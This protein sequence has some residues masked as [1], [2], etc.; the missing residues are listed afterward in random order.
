[1]TNQQLLEQFVKQNNEDVLIDYRNK[2]YDNLKE[3]S[4][5]EEKHTLWLLVIILFYLANTSIP[6]FTI[7]PATISNTT[8]FAKILPIV[9]IA[10]L[11]NLQSMTQ[12]QKELTKA[13]ETISASIFK[14]SI[15]AVTKSNFKSNYIYRMYLPYSFANFL[16]NTKDR[17]KKSQLIIFLTL[18]IPFVIVCFFPY[19]LICFML[20]DL[21]NNHF[22]D[23]LGKVS[24]FISLWLF[25]ILL[26]YMFS[27]FFNPKQLEIENKDN[28]A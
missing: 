11:F 18:L 10:M 2:L 14:Q 22:E 9:F 27:G 24:F 4:S 3:I 26:F 23:V 13:I 1:M 28:V 7:G 21:F 5:K 12:Y 8:I 25:L 20:Y 17:P 16:Y 15:Q 6:N 19:F